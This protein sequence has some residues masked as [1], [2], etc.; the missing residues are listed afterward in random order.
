MAGKHWQKYILEEHLISVLQLALSRND[1]G[2]A[3]DNYW[4]KPVDRNQYKLPTDKVVTLKLAN[5][6]ARVI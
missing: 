3:L 6:Y 5:A 4:H 1:N 2:F